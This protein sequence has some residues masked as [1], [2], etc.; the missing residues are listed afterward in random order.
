M[1]LT[2]HETKGFTLEEMDDVFDSG[3]PAWKKH[4]KVSRLENL[5]KDIEK[6][7]VTVVAP[8]T[9]GAVEVGKQE[10]I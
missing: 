3:H 6:G 10:K 5:A 8:G 7:N 1:F 9:G 4:D 2:A